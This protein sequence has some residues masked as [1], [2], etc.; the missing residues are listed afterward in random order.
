MKRTIVSIAIVL[1]SSLLMFQACKKDRTTVVINN[2]TNNTTTSWSSNISANSDIELLKAELKP[3]P[4]KKTAYISGYYWTDVVFQD[5]LKISI[6]GSGWK[7]KNGNN[8]TGNIEIEEYY[9]NSKGKCIL[10][11]KPTQTND[12]LLVT[13]GSYY[14]NFKKNGEE[15]TN[16]QYYYLD[17]PIPNK[18]SFQIF[19]ASEGQNWN[20][21]TDPNVFLNPSPWSDTAWKRDSSAN[22][23]DSMF[24]IPCKFKF[25]NCDYFYKYQSTDLC[26]LKVKLPE[27]FGN[28]NTN[29]FTLFLDENVVFNLYGDNNLKLFTT[30][31]G[32]SVPIG[33]NFKLVAYCKIK[34]KFYFVQK[35]IVATKDKTEEL[36]PVEVT[37]TQMETLIKSL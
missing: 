24:K 4:N 37:K 18:V 31:F 16:S 33:F 6:P 3:I 34:D 22:T 8:V 27:E 11:N 15:I 14:I 12:K 2:P 1:F 29:I 19:T 20:L 5:G 23:S 32:Y 21:S 13:G 30:G 28:T 36:N 26:V 10:M 25:I 7:D 17:I 9:I 35:D